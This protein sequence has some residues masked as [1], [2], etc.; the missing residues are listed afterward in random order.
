MKVLVAGDRGYIVA[1]MLPVLPVAGRRPDGL[2]LG[3]HE[4]CDLALARKVLARLACDVDLLSAGLVDD[5]LHRRP[6]GKLQASAAYIGQEARR[7]SRM[8]PTE[9]L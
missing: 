1:V 7:C 8:V 9:F 5:T 2:D 3:L 4:R 6:N